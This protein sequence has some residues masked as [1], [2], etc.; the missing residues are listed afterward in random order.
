ML[1]WLAGPAHGTPTGAGIGFSLRR[2]TA[3]HQLRHVRADGYP[4]RVDIVA[5][6]GPLG[7]ADPF[8]AMLRADNLA[9]PSA[10]ELV[11][12]EIPTAPALEDIAEPVILET[13]YTPTDWAATVAVFEVPGSTIPDPRPERRMPSLEDIARRFR[14]IDRCTCDLCL[15]G[16]SRRL[17]IPRA[18]DPPRFPLESYFPAQEPEAEH[19]A[20]DYGLAT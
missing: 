20:A 1:E 4:N 16:E 9:H 18:D 12:Q 6:L 17:S 7:L 11:L 15:E 3:L 5:L 8:L 2:P 13:A 14:T 19:P 10:A